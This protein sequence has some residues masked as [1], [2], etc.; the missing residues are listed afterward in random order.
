[1][2]RLRRCALL[3]PWLVAAAAPV[4][5]QTDAAVARAPLQ[6]ATLQR[7]AH[8]ADVRTREIDLLARQ[9]DL[10]VRSIAVERLP[11]VSALGQSQYQSDVPTAPFNGPD[12]RPVFSSPKFTYDASLRVDQRL[13][14]AGI[15]PRRELARAD[16]AESQARVRTT[17]FAVRQEVNEAFFTAALVQEQL[18]ALSA[19]LD[20]ETRRRLAGPEFDA[21]AEAVV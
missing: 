6:L 14:D 15:E 21:P 16:L 17:L 11:S 12:G 1:M 8:D 2:T 7:E 18:G 4:L 9:T 3:A 13:Y 19:A 20:L 5:A 10:R